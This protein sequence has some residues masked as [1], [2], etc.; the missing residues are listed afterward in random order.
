[1][2]PGLFFTRKRAEGLSIW[3]M[4][5]LPTGV[6]FGVAIRESWKMVS[7]SKDHELDRLLTCG[8]EELIAAVRLMSAKDCERHARA[9]LG[10]V[11]GPTFEQYLTRIVERMVPEDGG[12][13]PGDIDEYYFAVRDL[14]PHIPSDNDVLGRL[15]CLVMRMGQLRLEAHRTNVRR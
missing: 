5:V 15:A 9:I 8:V 3:G 13:P 6:E 10:R 1:L 12:D 4:S 14:F 2:F 11:G 7:A